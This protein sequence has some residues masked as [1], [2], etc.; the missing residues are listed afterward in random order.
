MNLLSNLSTGFKTL[1]GY[2][3]NSFAIA[4]TSSGLWATRPTGTIM[5]ACGNRLE[6][7]WE[8]MEPFYSHPSGDSVIDIHVCSSASVE[9]V[10]IAD[11]YRTGFW[12]HAKRTLLSR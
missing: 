2:V 3:P 8:R 6:K 10:G 12:Q 4:L 1:P 9:V 5:P 7:I 11:T